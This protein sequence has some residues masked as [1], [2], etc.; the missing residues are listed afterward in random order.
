VA[1]FVQA[2]S[3]LALH[4]SADAA[5][6]PPRLEYTL[7]ILLSD[8]IWPHLSDPTKR[9]L[10]L[11]SKS[12]R[13]AVDCN[14]TRVELTSSRDVAAWRDTKCWQPKEL[15]IHTEAVSSSGWEYLGSPLVSPVL[16]SLAKLQAVSV[17]APEVPQALFQVGA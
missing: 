17:H 9:S 15:V 14:V 10:R 16:G 4:A 5:E 6:T 11:V 1:H 13:E 12:V 3:E 8:H 2:W 7:C